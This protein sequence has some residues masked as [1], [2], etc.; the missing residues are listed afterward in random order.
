M[1]VGLAKSAQYLWAVSLGFECVLLAYLLVRRQ[2]RSYPAFAFYI[3][4]DILQAAAVFRAYE[5]WGF[6]STASIHF[7]WA[8]QGL[9]VCARA[10]AVAELCRHLLRPYR[11]VWALAWRFLLI[12]AATSALYPILTAGWKWETTVL[13]VDLGLELTMVFVIVALFVF[14]RYYEIV[15]DSVLRTMGAG[16]L[17]LS[18]SKVVNDSILQQRLV[19][20]IFLWRLLGLLAF[21]VSLCLW[22]S[23][24]HKLGPSRGQRPTLLPPDVY[25]SM[26]PEMNE[27]LRR[28]NDQLKRL[29]RMRAFGS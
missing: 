15:A 27:R 3:V 22:F 25:G 5:V 23:A 20:Y 24:L 2:Y 12:C 14:A 1:M 28:L 4:I 26:A 6:S 21:M 17:V 11:G 7:S 9:V 8:T 10:V 16:F 13:Q 19:E 29:V 18:C